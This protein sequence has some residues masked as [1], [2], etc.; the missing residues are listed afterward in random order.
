MQELRRRRTCEGL[1][2]GLPTAERN[3]ELL[4]GLPARHCHCDRP[5]YLVKPVE[6]PLL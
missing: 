3:R 1:L 4:A 2:R 6:A 5:A